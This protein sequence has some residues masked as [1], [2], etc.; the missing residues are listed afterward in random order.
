MLVQAGKLSAGV[1]ASLVQLLG[2][3]CHE[4]QAAAAS[5]FKQLMNGNRMLI[6]ASGQP[7]CERCI[8]TAMIMLGERCH[9]DTWHALSVVTSVMHIG[10]SANAGA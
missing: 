5:A 8:C 6:M 9:L 1:L 2:S 7:H 3:Q 4:V 10:A